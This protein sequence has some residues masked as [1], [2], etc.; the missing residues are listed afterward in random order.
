MDK[1]DVVIVGGGLVGAS[2]ACAL[3]GAGLRIA[4]V[5]AVPLRAANQP[6]Y[7]DRTLA[8][9]LTSTRILAALGAWEHMVDAGTPIRRIHVTSQGQ[10]GRVVLR[11]EECGVYAFGYVVEAKLVGAGI[12]E[13]LDDREDITL[14]CP[15]RVSDYSPAGEF[16]TLSVDTDSGMARIRA[17]LVVGAD[18]ANSRLRKLC[19]IGATVKDYDQSAV[20]ANVTPALTHDNTA[21]ERLTTTG[22]FA[23]LP[24]RGSRCGLVWV[25]R[26]RE[27]DEL[28]GA[29]DDTFLRGAQ[30]RFG[31]RL[32][33]LQ[34][35]GT[36]SSYPLRQVRPTTDVARRAVLIGNAAHTVHPVAA[37][38]FNLGLRDVAVLSG[39][40]LEASAQRADPG[41]DALLSKYSVTRR[42]DHDAIFRA[43]DRLVRLFGSDFLPVEMARGMGLTALQIAPPLR[44]ALA[45][46]AMGFGVPRVAEWIGSR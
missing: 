8:L 7:D 3:S 20:V 40:L 38:G 36:R 46:R 6:S 25:V 41:N 34:R 31:W 32:G 24:H 21:Y 33:L 35:V 28:M 15:A 43:T 42:G 12:Y 27:L 2:L 44:R 23:V 30:R 18:G 26:N 14:L 4:M 11:A 13:T 10:F 22:P 19:G 39:L 17:R 9:S 1:F 5:E 16:A 29:D 37:Q 45:R